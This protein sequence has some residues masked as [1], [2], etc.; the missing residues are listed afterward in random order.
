MKLSS[1][2]A[3]SYI[4][5]TST[6]ISHQESEFKCTIFVFMESKITNLAFS[7]LATT[8]KTI[9]NAAFIR[10]LAVT[11]GSILVMGHKT[12]EVD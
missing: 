5:L 11:Q 6:K 3:Y 4:S 7:R 2:E 12:T 9:N 8:K 10:F 1:V